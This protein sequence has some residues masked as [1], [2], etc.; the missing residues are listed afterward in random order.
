ML[1]PDYLGIPG[2]VVQGAGVVI[3]AMG[4]YQFKE[5]GQESVM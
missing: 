3:K 5:M 4:G 1:K 2:K